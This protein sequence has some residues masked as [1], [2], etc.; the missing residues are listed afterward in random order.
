MDA[1]KYARLQAWGGIFQLLRTQRKLSTLERMTLEL[2]R[3]SSNDFDRCLHLFDYLS[4][5]E[6]PTS[7]PDLAKALGLGN[8]TL[9]QTLRALKEGGFEFKIS[10]STANWYEPLEIPPSSM[11]RYLITLRTRKT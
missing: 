5:L 6:E 8:E 2:L 9:V 10:V 11:L 7:T 3:Q 4:K 1:G